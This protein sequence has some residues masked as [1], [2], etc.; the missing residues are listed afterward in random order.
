MTLAPECFEPAPEYG[1]PRLRI[2][3]WPNDATLHELQR[4]AP[5][6]QQGAGGRKLRDR[7]FR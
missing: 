2:V 3:G 5:L 4:C 6:P 7:R 1:P